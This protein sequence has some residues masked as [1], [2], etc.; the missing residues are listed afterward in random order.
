M[1]SPARIKKAGGFL[2]YRLYKKKQKFCK[3]IKKKAKYQTKLIILYI[4]KHW[5][6]RQ[7]P[8]FFLNK[9]TEKLAKNF[10][11]PMYKLS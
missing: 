1:E 10:H 6:N 3:K 5:S 2:E 9:T 4:F 11:K 7:I 8:Y